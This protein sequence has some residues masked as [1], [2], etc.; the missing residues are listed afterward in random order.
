MSAKT[1]FHIHFNFRRTES[2]KFGK[3][4]STKKKKKKRAKSL[5]LDKLTLI[6]Q[7]Y[8]PVRFGRLGSWLFGFSS[9]TLRIKRA[10][11]HIGITDA[12][13]S[14]ES[15]ILLLIQFC[16]LMSF[17]YPRGKNSTSLKD[18]ESK[19]YSHF[20]TTV[21][22]S[23]RELRKGRQEQ[24]KVTEDSKGCN[25]GSTGNQGRV[26]HSH[27]PLPWGLLLAP[28]VHILLQQHESKGRHFFLNLLFLVPEEQI[29]SGLALD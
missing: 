29:P 28:R 16:Q 15:L 25:T 22:S 5:K 9:T 24:D 14:T 7:S 19:G 1:N 17:S 6:S 3:K 23:Q 4:Q 13:S 12:K 21:G 26:K 8:V 20:H 27:W 18:T 11:I 10:A 2:K